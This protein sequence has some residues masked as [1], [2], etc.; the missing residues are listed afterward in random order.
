MSDKPNIVSQYEQRKAAG[1]SLYFDPVELEDI[2]HFYAEEGRLDQQEEVLRL[3]RELHP[4]DFV[5]GTLE[6]EFALNIDDADACL[7][8]L[9]PIFDEDNIMHCILKSGA[10]AQKG[11]LPRAIDYG[12][13]AVEGEDPLIAYDVG[14]GFMNAGQP[15]IALRYYTRC[16]E[17]YPED[18]RTLQGIIYCLNQVGTPDE[19][20]QYADRALDLDSFCVDA[21]LA[22][23]NALGE[24]GKWKEA[25]ECCDYAMAIQPENGDC[26]LM[27]VNCCVQQ[28]RH[29]EALHFAQEAAKRVD[30]GSKA[31]VLLLAAHL[32][33]E[34]NQME[35][36]QNAIWE[37]IEACPLDREILN[38]AIYAFSDCHA[39]AAA[40]VLLKDRMQR[41][42]DKMDPQLLMLMG[43]LYTQMNNYEAAIEP[44]EQLVKVA[45]SP[46]AWTMLASTYM[47]L[48]KFRKA[49]KYLQMANAEDPMW[50]TYVLTAVC[51]HEMGWETA[52][53]NNYILAHNL[54]AK[55]AYDL[56]K[57]LSPLLTESFEKKQI[58][59]QAEQWRHTQ[60]V[61]QLLAAETRQAESESAEQQIEMEEIETKANKK[62]R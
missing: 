50:Q 27:K 38:R 6:A 56:L 49:Y 18:I 33:S 26:I 45:P 62:T 59:R 4:D 51:A 48:N 1:E 17:A 47:S 20:I 15:T 53:A 54:S 46:T 19:V 35:E 31:N 9:E 11:D 37:A 42:G 5:T 55:G 22:K 30:N 41:E 28:E 39:P 3:A 32:F 7:K 60:L 12:E 2:F 24:L 10:L 58:F 40:I 8:Y 44:Y 61:K 57:G 13:M 23:G 52:A 16:L 14:L 43:E 34:K 25:E 36:A 21:W 29:D